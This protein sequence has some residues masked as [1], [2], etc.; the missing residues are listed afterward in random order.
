[1]QTGLW[2]DGTGKGFRVNWNI[3][4]RNMASGETL[5]HMATW[6]GK[7]EIAQLLIN[8]GADIHAVDSTVSMCTAMH[9]AA[10]RGWEDIIH[11]LA[12]AGALSFVKD[13]H[14]DTP[15]HWAARNRHLSCIRA[16]MFAQDAHHN[17]AKLVHA[18]NDKGQRAVDLADR[19]SIARL[20]DA[21]EDFPAGSTDLPRLWLSPTT[22]SE[23][24]REKL[25][26]ER[27][28]KRYLT[29]SPRSKFPTRRG[30]S[31]QRKN[32]NYLRSRAA[33]SK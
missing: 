3:N 9:L 19:L 29:N 12:T 28:M 26:Q 23:K 33:Y 21:Y 4:T 31:S 27:Q 1:M 7:C 25:M 2:E 8:K 16:L 15:L 30:D 17:P 13:Q 32:R 20:L 11:V 14:G 24:H 10:R 18:T 5:L 22:P 6:T